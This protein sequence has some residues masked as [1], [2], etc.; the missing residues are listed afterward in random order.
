[1]GL[2]A[3][4]IGTGWAA[5]G[6]AQALQAAGVGVVAVCGRTRERASAL[7][8]RLGIEGVRLDWR[9]ALAELKPDIVA[10]ATPG[11]PHRE[12]AEAAAQEGCH[13]F[14]D[15]PMGVNAADARA[16][17]QAVRKAGVRH[18]YG[19]TSCLEP[20]FSFLRSLLADDAVGAL[21]GIDVQSQMGLSPLL[22]FSWFH[23]LSEGGGMLN[24]IFTHV[25]A[26]VLF[27]TGGRPREVVGEARCL[28]PRAPV[29]Q[30]IHDFRQWFTP[31]S[32]VNEDTVWRE[33]DA[34][35]EYSVMVRLSLP[36][37]EPVTARFFGSLN[38]LN[39]E[40]GRFALYG[41][42]GTLVMAGGGDAKVILHHDAARDGWHQLTMPAENEPGWLATDSNEQRN[43][44][45][46]VRRFVADIRGEPTSFYPTFVDG[47][48]ASEIIDIVRGRAGWSPVPDWRG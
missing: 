9:S 24:Q 5:E 29:G 44:K 42:K 19:A 6:H 45:A 34:D 1:M 18:A 11:G 47:C 39:P 10:I 43:W 35:T 3:V 2:R 37:G 33:A 40:G 38:T 28:V 21:T 46:V 26:Q 14:C 15:K 31:V 8:T 41:T 7:A 27:V 17:L 22:P 48:E 32:E 23:R 25:L 36:S 12:M 30:A 4:V 20:A 16:M 13:I